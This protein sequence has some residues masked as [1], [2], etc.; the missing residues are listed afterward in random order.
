MVS[1]IRLIYVF[2]DTGL[3]WRVVTMVVRGEVPSEARRDQNSGADPTPT[4]N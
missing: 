3:G 1:T 2:A 4:P